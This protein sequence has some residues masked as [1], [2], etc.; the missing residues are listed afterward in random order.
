[1]RIF[2]IQYCMYVYIYIYIYIYIYNRLKLLFNMIWSKA[3]WLEGNIEKVGTV[4][5][6]WIEKKNILWLVGINALRAIAEQK[7]PDEKWKLFQ[8]VKVEQLSSNIFFLYE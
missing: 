7:I 1:M 3:V 6:S 4:P 2:Y 8:L 5:I